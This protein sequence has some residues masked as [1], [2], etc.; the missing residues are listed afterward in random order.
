MTGTDRRVVHDE[1]FWRVGPRAN[2]GPGSLHGAEDSGLLGEN[3]FHPSPDA[4]PATFLLGSVV[5]PLPPEAGQSV[6]K[7]RSLWVP[8]GYHGWDAVRDPD[9]VYLSTVGLCLSTWGRPVAWSPRCLFV[10]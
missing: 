10:K 8:P 1:G 9:L 5:C 2:T 6:R 3:R 7:E 4:E